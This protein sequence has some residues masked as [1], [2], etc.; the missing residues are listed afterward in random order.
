MVSGAAAV[1]QTGFHQK[2]NGQRCNA[3]SC[4]TGWSCVRVCTPCLSSFL[5]SPKS[6]ETPSA[7]FP[8]DKTGTAF[9]AILHIFWLGL[10]DSWQGD[11]CFYA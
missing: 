5:C 11:Q 8:N 3:A 7:G 9:T 2:S 1:L 4:I 10:Q 6:H